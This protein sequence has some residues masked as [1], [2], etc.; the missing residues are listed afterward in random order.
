MHALWMYIQCYTYMH[1]CEWCACTCILCVW[2]VG[3]GEGGP[4]SFCHDDVICISFQQLFTALDGANSVI[5][6]IL[7]HVK[8][9]MAYS[10]WGSLRTQHYTDWLL[11]TVH[12]S[13]KVCRFGLCTILTTTYVY[14]MVVC[15]TT[16]MVTI[17]TYIYLKLILTNTNFDM[18]R[19]KF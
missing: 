16:C 17:Y 18:Y 3:V 2:G 12:K 11:I 1:M 7:L 5:Y 13:I 10:D 4:V 19:Y 15:H 14:H 8:P 9:Y 6:R